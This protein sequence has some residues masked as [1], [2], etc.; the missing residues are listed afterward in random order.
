MKTSIKYILAAGLAIAL[1]GACNKQSADIPAP[2]GLVT[3]SVSLPQFT[4]VAATD[5]ESAAGLSWTW[6]EGDELNVI[7]KTSSVFTIDEGFTANK[8]TFTGAPVKGDSFDIIYP[9]SFAAP[10]AMESMAFAEQAQKD[11]SAKDHLQYFALLQGV[12]S[13]ESFEFSQAWAGANGATIKLGG[14]LKITATLPAETVEVTKLSVKASA[15]VFHADNGETMTDVLAVTFEDSVLPESK[16]LTAWLT[17]SWHDTPIPAGTVLSFCAAAGDFTWYNDVQLDAEKT[18]L[19]GAVNTITLDASGWYNTGRYTGGAGTEISPW[20]ITKPE[21]MLFINEDLKAGEIRYYKLGAD[22]DMSGIADW[23]P[24]N[25]ADP[26]DKKIDFDGAGHTISGF[27]CD[28]P[29]YPSFFGVL[30]GKCHDVTFTDALITG[31]TKSGCG[32]LGGYCGTGANEGEVYNVH[33]QGKVDFTGNKTGIGGM[34]GN[35]GN[36]YIHSSSADVIVVSGKNYVGGLFGLDGDHCVVEDCWTSGSVTGNQR[37]G[38]IAGGLIKKGS[39]IRNC[40]STSEVSASFCIG[41]IAG[42]CNLDQKSGTPEETRPEN[43]IEKCIAWNTS[44]YALTV[45]PGDKSH[46]SGGAI[47]GFTSRY[48][49]LTDGMRKADLS[50]QEY[51]DLFGLY[52]QENASPDTPLVVNEVEGATYNYPYHGKAAS[53]G[54]TLSQVAQSIGW[55]ADKWDFSGDVPVLK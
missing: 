46:Y 4:R 30:Y 51:S 21:Q 3:V 5:R 35:V 23:V 45:T 52:D 12:T 54:A 40:Y 9:G 36:G 31:T 32:I 1:L 10:A 38:G 37:V 47:A 15:P 53:A 27:R 19:S 49:Y 29:T 34:F 39:V 8:A 11:A 44:I 24:V 2:A 16:T 50:F 55:S 18:I 20:I 48:N 41:G 6:E 7:G 43:V 13:L 17:T 22:I 42:H 14:V 33:V 28:Y 26:Y 25:Y